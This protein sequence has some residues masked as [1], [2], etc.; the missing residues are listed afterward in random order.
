MANTQIGGADFCM[1]Q[2]PFPASEWAQHL[3]SAKVQLH[4]VNVEWP[5][6]APRDLVSTF[7]E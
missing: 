3:L 5:W 7:T 6:A 1:R 2:E 4:L